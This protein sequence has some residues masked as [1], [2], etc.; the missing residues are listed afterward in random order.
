[1]VDMDVRTDSKWLGFILDQILSNALKYTKS[2]GEVKIW[3]DTEASGKKVLHMEDNGRGIKEEDLP[4][5]F[6]Q[7]FTG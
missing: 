4:R 1:N 2:G 5:V 6:E 3:C 7:G